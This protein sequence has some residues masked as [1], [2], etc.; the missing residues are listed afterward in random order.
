MALADLELLRR[1]LAAE[2]AGDWGEALAAAAAAAA[3][4]PHGDQARWEAAI[5]RLPALEP[6][7]PVAD[8]PAVRIGSEA[9]AATRRPSARRCWHW[10]R[11][12]R[13]RSRSTASTWTPS[14]AR[15]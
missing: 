12:A 10:R 14:G 9:D 5:G 13:G 3:A 8:G 1:T 6:A 15:T 4:R 7:M 2:G 11:G